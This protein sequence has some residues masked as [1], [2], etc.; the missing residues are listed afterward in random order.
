MY[1]NYSLA[2]TFEHSMLTLN[3]KWKEL[4]SKINLYASV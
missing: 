3:N 1:Q 2:L 4:F